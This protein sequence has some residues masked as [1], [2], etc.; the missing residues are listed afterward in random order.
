MTPETIFELNI[1]A[2]LTHVQ[3]YYYDVK[4]NSVLPVFPE[5]IKECTLYKIKEF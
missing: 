5:H 4:N 3:L 1:L 2:K